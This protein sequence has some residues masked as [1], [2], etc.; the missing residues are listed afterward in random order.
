VG[1]AVRDEARERSLAEI[2]SVSQMPMISDDFVVRWRE[3][4]SATQRSG[5]AANTT[6]G[7]DGIDGT[8]CIKTLTDIFYRTIYHREA[9]QP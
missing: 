3:I 4:C 6:D 2:I 7:I 8:A 9:G 5:Q 1:G